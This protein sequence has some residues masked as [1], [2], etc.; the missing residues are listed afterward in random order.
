MKKLFFF[1][2]LFYVTPVA[3][4]SQLDKCYLW[5]NPDQD[6]VVLR[7]TFCI[8]SVLPSRSYTIFRK[9]KDQS[10]FVPIGISTAVPIEK[11]KE[12]STIS[13]KTLDTIRRLID[14]SADPRKSKDIRKKAVISLQKLHLLRPEQ[15]ARLFGLYFVDTTASSKKIYDYRIEFNQQ[16]VVELENVSL[17]YL[18][19]KTVRNFQV[20]SMTNSVQLQWKLFNDFPRG[21]LGYIVYKKSP[22][23]YD[24]VR[25]PQIHYVFNS[26]DTEL[27]D[28]TI[29]DRN[30]FPGTRY[31]YAITPIDVFGREGLRSDTMSVIPRSSDDDKVPNNF[32]ASFVGD[33]VVLSW[34]KPAVPLVNGYHIYRYPTNNKEEK[35]RITK[36]PISADTKMFVDKPMGQLTDFFSYVITTINNNGVESATSSEQKVA[37]PNTAAPDMPNYLTI[38][39][40]RKGIILSWQRSKAKDVIG[41]EL[42]R[43]ESEDGEFYPV[44][45]MLVKD[46]FYVDILASNENASTFWYQVRA[47]DRYGNKS[48][49]TLVTP[50]F[51]VGNSTPKSV[52]LQ[53]AFV[54]DDKVVLQWTNEQNQ[55]TQGFWVNRYN[56]TSY[57]PITIN[58]AFII[59]NEFVDSS[60][61]NKQQYWYEVIAV[62]SNFNYSQPSNRVFV[63][64]RKT[65][66]M[67]TRY[68]D[69][70]YIRQDTLHV[71]IA[72]GI[73]DESVE[74]MIELAVNT[75][76]FTSLAVIQPYKVTYFSAP[77]EHKEQFLTVRIRKRDGRSPWQN[78]EDS[79]TITVEN[80][81]Q[82]K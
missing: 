31:T 49:L 8:D 18:E 19:A 72:D 22:E 61:L 56:D 79:Q 36:N 4:L 73:N 23:I 68:V 63:D 70:A 26:T 51:A 42:F 71:Y 30:V 39:G 81:K 45:S 47:V 69:T 7:W 64:L 25:Q 21:I 33:S 44:E 29:E 15:Y 35:V 13:S 66:S 27:I 53:D 24:F 59:G 3:V 54:K 32:A 16:E 67:K 76:S 2:I 65:Y 50:G 28:F 38:Q 60:M 40:I 10:D 43:S 62:D 6:G 41:Y 9:E 11:W 75:Q 48:S 5:A 1:L 55:K 57:S 82:T 80:T 34:E 14:V 74:L 52:Q 12:Y 78:P 37:L 58:S 20:K 46:T 17:R 77:I